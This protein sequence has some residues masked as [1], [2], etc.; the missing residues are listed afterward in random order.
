MYSF[1]NFLCS[2]TWYDLKQGAYN[3]QFTSTGAY[4]RYYILLSI[5]GADTDDSLSVTLDGK[6]LPWKTKG[7]K[8][9]TFY[10]WTSSTAGFTKGSHVLQV[11][12]GGSF[13]S[14][15]IKQLCN[16][17][18][19]EYMGEDQ[20]HMD[21]PEYIGLYP[22]YD[23]NKRKSIRPNNEKCL[24]RNMTSPHFCNVCQE[25]MWQQFM[26]RISFIDDVIVTGKSVEAKL[27]PLG[28]FRPKT[29]G[30]DVEAVGLGEKYS[31]QW[32]NDGQEVVQFRDQVK[33][34]TSRIPNPSSK[35]TLKVAFTTP[36]VRVDSKNVMKSEKSFTIGRASLDDAS[37]NNAND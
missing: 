6:P 12:A 7:L 2:V 8:D 3:I 28:Q 21:D 37:Q 13:N 20:F 1:H 15:I 16:A 31:L 35:W 14:P 27:I 30:G 10:T 18:I 25:N 26:T 19:S 22:T 23:I 17:E 11:K 29:N 34:D 36:S 33:I 4:K 32:L 9:R 24:M 5:S